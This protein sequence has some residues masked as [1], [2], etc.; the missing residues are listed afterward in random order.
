[1]KLS[2]AQLKLLREFGAGKQLM[3]LRLGPETSLRWKAGPPF[4]PPGINYL[5]LSKLQE[6]RL[7]FDTNPSWKGGTYAIT[8]KGR[9]YLE[10]LCEE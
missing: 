9:E 1:M 7:V 4:G 6:L 5:T 8:D 10:G 2:K 3:E